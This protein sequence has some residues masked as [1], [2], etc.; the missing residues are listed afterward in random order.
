MRDLPVTAGTRVVT[1]FCR[2]C[3]AYCG[4]KVT[5]TDGVVERV[6][7]DPD[8]PASQGFSCVKG[9]ALPEQINHA[10]RLLAPLKRARDGTLRPVSSATA[11]DEVAAGLS[12]IID[13]Y[14]SRAVAL[15]GGNGVLGHAAG[16][17]VASR[18]WRAI[19]SP[20]VFSSASIDQPGKPIAH[21]MHGRWGAGMAALPDTDVWM[22]MG[23]NPLVSLWAGTGIQNPGAE[24]RRVKKAG[25]ALVVVDPRRT[26][27]AALADIHLQIKPG[28]D[29]T[30]LAGLI[31][32]ILTTGREDKSFCRKHVRGVQALR[33]AVEPYDRDLI[34]GRTGLDF[35]DVSRVADLFVSAG[36]AGAS[37]GTGSNMSGWGTLTEY[38]MMSL[39]SIT[40]SWRQVGDVVRN[41]GVL[42]P[43]RQWRAQAEPLPPGWDTG[44]STR[45]RGLSRSVVGMPTATAAEEILTE[46]PGQVRALVVIGGNP[47]ASWPDQLSAI[48]AM[49][50]LEL[51]VCVDLFENATTQFAD[52][53]FAGK[54]PFEVPATTQ[55]MEEAGVSYPT[56]SNWADP[57]AMYTPAVLD[58]PA[59][60]DVLDEA[61]IF[62]QLAARMGIQ[63]TLR[64]AALD[65]RA[66]ADIDDIIE[67]AAANGRVPL[68]RVKQHEHG[69]SGE[70]GQGPVVLPPEP[71]HL[72]RLEVGFGPMME[73]LGR[74]RAPAGTQPQFGYLLISRRMTQVCNSAVR[75]M[76][77]TGA[78][79]YNPAYIN[80]ADLEELGLHGGD[81]IRIQSARAAIRAIAEPAADLRRGVVSCAHSW[82]SSPEHDDALQTDGSN[83]GRLISNDAEFDQWSGIPLMSAIPVRLSLEPI[84][85]GSD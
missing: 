2:I 50:S 34:V 4:V 81:V 73:Q 28:E 21:S 33:D 6:A 61:E 68:S 67:A 76:P 60:S 85:I 32:L 36:R 53:V 27:T 25:T 16:N 29:A 40:G 51:L 62:H 38:L 63:L 79:S 54:H 84:P 30:L 55:L 22:F 75:N 10:D 45:I 74:L 58:P 19:R 39:I 52:Y 18:L 13:R 11:L 64:G 15:Y 80:P 35:D 70:L 1:S 48:A 5:V 3:Q 14:G 59:G 65:M 7:G 47:V 66:S 42:V 71:G 56:T 83:V 17:V 20:M 37:A 78:P 24:L 31:R 77:G 44:E 8:N 46:G 41:P 12:A 23:T 9:R 43:E 82:G 26:R 72:E 49:K 69:Y 57:Y